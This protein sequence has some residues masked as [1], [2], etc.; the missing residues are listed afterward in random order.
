MEQYV[1]GFQ[2]FHAGEETRPV[3]SCKFLLIK[4][5]QRPPSDQGD[6]GIDLLARTICWSVA[7]SSGIIQISVLV[8]G[9]NRW[10]FEKG[11][12][13]T[14]ATKV[15]PQYITRTCD[16]LSK[17]CFLL[18]RL[19]YRD[20]R[21]RDDRNRKYFM[22]FAPFTRFLQWFTI[23]HPISLRKPNWSSFFLLIRS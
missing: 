14:T 13:E 20:A 23:S 11:A 21:P 2:R 18:F 8:Y 9:H 22:E 3:N 12:A 1:K 6:P 10:K 7:I 5:R 19:T 15:K 4:N 17:K 16:N